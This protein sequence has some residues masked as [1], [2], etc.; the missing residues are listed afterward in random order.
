MNLDTLSA[1]LVN[2]VRTVSDTKR[3]F[4]AHHAR[5]INA[6]YRRVV[7]ELMVEMHLLSVSVDFVH[8]SLYA[9]GVVTSYNRFMA[10]YQPESDVSSIFAALCNAVE[11]NAEQYHRDAESIKASVEGLS[12]EDYKQQVAAAKTGGM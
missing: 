7:E 9:L 5:P 3:S 12:L 4:Y 6:I 2:N 8:D 11:S 1:S 10:G